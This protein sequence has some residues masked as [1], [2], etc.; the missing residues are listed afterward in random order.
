M[1]EEE[2]FPCTPEKYRSL[3]K[4]RAQ[5]LG[6]NPRLRR[7]FDSSDVVNEA[8]LKAWE[9]R[10]Q[11]EGTTEAE[12]VAWLQR[13]LRNQA[14]NMIRRELA[15]HRNPTLEVYEAAVEESSARWDAVLADDQNSPSGHLQ[16]QELLLRLACAL[17]QL[18]E[19]QRHAVI[20]RDLL[21]LS[22]AEI[23]QQMGRTERAVGGLLHRGRERLRELMNSPGG[24]SQEC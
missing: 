20:A 4:M 5:E 18:S 3:L 14:I 17:E 11:F 13:I 21:G 15:H 19:D 8:I 24:N 7:R 9:K 10:D 1:P 23:A 22:L 2:R 16:Q 6:V 12:Y